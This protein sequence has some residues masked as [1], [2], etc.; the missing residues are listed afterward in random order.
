MQS[1][2]RD[3]IEKK[4]ASIRKQINKKDYAPI[5]TPVEP[6]VIMDDLPTMEHVSLQN[7]KRSG[8]WKNARVIVAH[9]NGKHWYVHADL[10]NLPGKFAITEE[11]HKMARRQIPG[12]ETIT[13][14]RAARGTPPHELYEYLARCFGLNRGNQS[15]RLWNADSIAWL[16]MIKPP[17]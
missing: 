8:K 5:V 14:K 4:I 1:R 16:P 11:A 10:K 17:L 3:T 7:A 12:V 9:V 15:F 2:P 6:A 13:V